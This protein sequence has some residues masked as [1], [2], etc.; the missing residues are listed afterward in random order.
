MSYLNRFIVE[1]LVGEL[2]GEG[3]S[4]VKFREVPLTAVEEAV[5]VVHEDVWFP[6]VARGHSNILHHPIL[7]LVPFQINIS[8]LLKCGTISS[9]HK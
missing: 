1:K 4:T 2:V 3:P 7:R 8:P 5:P 6:E 9:K